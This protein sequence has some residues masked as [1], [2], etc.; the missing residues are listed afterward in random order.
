MRALFLTAV[1]PLALLLA[2]PTALAASSD[3]DLAALEKLMREKL[4]RGAQVL[5]AA[6]G[7]PV[8][9]NRGEFTD[10]ATGWRYTVAGGAV[11]DPPERF[12]S[13]T[14]L[15]G[16]VQAS[17][18]ATCPACANLCCFP[19]ASA[20]YDN[21]CYQ[22]GPRRRVVS[23]AGYSLVE[24]W[25]YMPEVCGV[26]VPKDINIPGGW[27]EHSNLYFTVR[28]PWTGPKPAD[29]DDYAFLEVGL[30]RWVPAGSGP[31]DPNARRFYVYWQYENWNGSAWEWVGSSDRDW[32]GFASGTPVFSILLVEASHNDN[33]HAPGVVWFLTFNSDATIW[34]L[35]EILVWGVKTCQSQT[36]QPDISC[37]QAVGRVSMLVVEPTRPPAGWP[38]CQGHDGAPYEWLFGN[39][40]NE[41]IEDMRVGYPAPSPPTGCERDSGTGFVKCLWTAERTNRT[42]V[43]PYPRDEPDD[44]CSFF[45]DPDPGEDPY[46]CT[47]YDYVC[48]EERAPYYSETIHYIQAFCNSYRYTGDC[49][50][51][52]TGYC[53][54]PWPFDKLDYGNCNNANCPRQ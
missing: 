21:F 6:M 33:T 51:N 3:P 5:S 47:Y 43:P 2:H 16:P 8:D 22:Y 38:C 40:E 28:R 30:V 41:V 19:C 17:A 14:S 31:G 1:F 27:P 25:R 9:V 32:A 50:S 54:C 49:T 46:D 23:Q 52:P 42:V 45:G 12:V 39:Q 18:D 36:S 15:F 53:S 26:D 24:G 35:R 48:A 4:E 34:W 13:D 11:Y 20:P 10:T 37:N 44:F 7:K 29:P